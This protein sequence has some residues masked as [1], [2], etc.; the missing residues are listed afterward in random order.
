MSRCLCYKRIFDGF[1][2]TD[3]VGFEGIDELNL[4]SNKLNIFQNCVLLRKFFSENICQVTYMSV[5]R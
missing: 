1:G 5:L 3:H 4:S 2:L